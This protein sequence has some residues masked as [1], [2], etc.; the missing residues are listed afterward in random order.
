M[1]QA[2]R[3]IATPVVALAVA[4]T[5]VGAVGTPA[6]AAASGCNIPANAY[7]CTTR[8]VTANSTAHAIQ[9]N[10]WTGPDYVATDCYV[11]DRDNGVEV[12]HLHRN[13]GQTTAARKTINGL[14]NR[15]FMVVVRGS[16]G[17]LSRSAGGGSISN[18]S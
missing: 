10:C 15:Y 14:Y 12:G 16:G 6:F 11:Y 18:G 8:T 7:N 2:V 9:A 5:L 3:R 4:A 17:N 13:A 1:N